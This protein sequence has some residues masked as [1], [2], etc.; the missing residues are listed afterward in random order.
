MERLSNMNKLFAYISSH[1]NPSHSFN[2]F[3]VIYTRLYAFMGAV[4]YTL[5]I[6]LIRFWIISSQIHGLCLS[7]WLASNVLICFMKTY[8]R[9]I[10]ASFLYVYGTV[11]MTIHHSHLLMSIMLVDALHII[12]AL[13]YFKEFDDFCSINLMNNSSR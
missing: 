3:I 7:L 11:W 6:P 13:R 9:L 1:D 5:T 12:F 8:Y 2:T 10:F 4:I